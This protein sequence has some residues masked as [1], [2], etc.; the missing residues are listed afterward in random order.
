VGVR[1]RWRGRGIGEALLSHSLNVFRRRGLAAAA[2]NVDAENI[3]GAL[4]LYRKVGMEPK[5][6]FT[7]WSKPL[8]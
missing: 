2:L 8:L 6:S 1:P 5:P 4:R 7:I 3:T